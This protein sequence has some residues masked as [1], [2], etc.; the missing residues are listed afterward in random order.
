MIR[1]PPSEAFVALFSINKKIK[2]SIKIKHHLTILKTMLLTIFLIPLIM[3]SCTSESSTTSNSIK[4]KKV[5]QKTPTKTADPLPTEII[6]S[7]SSE[8]ETKGKKREKSAP[9]GRGKSRLQMQ[10]DMYNT[11]EKLMKQIEATGEISK[12]EVIKYAKDGEMYMSIYGDSLAAEYA[13]NAADL[14]RGIGDYTKALNMW[15][16]VYKAYAKDHPKAPHALFQC[17]FTYDSVLDRKDLAKTLYTSFL[18]KYPDHSLAKDAQL[19]LNNLDKSPE[20]LIKEFQK[21][22]QN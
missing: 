17:A 16:L 6:K 11:H 22:N 7:V 20:D 21:K 12:A 2:M 14:Y 15:L 19:S 1:G 9:L 13:F 3:G 5:D 18:K 8:M 10:E 4:E